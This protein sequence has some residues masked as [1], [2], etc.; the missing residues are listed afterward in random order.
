MTGAQ[1]R[2]AVVQAVAAVAC[3]AAIAL[4]AVSA[5]PAARLI[6]VLGVFTLAPGA[7]IVPALQPRSVAGELGI[8][9]ATSLASVAL[10]AQAMLWLG[11]WSP[12]AATYAVA[13]VCLAVL[14]ARAIRARRS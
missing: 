11:L 8:V 9:I 3:V 6:A 7:A 2:R 13:G 10:V 5:A 12:D 4:V 14:C 1:H